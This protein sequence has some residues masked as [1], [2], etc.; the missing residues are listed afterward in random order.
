MDDDDDMSSEY[1]SE[2]NA[3]QVKL[4]IAG[5]LFGFANDTPIKGWGQAHLQ[6]TVRI[7]IFTVIIRFF[8]PWIDAMPNGA[9]V[10]KKKILSD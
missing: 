10:K 6:W 2:F 7:P 5:E 3:Q 9:P 8:R 4:V 1:L